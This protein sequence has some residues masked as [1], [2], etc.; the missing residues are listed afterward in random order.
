M[1]CA[2]ELAFGQHAARSIAVDT[3]SLNPPF[4]FNSG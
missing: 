3:P 2:H 1:I 4:A